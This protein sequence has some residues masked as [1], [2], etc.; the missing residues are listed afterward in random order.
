M[1]DKGHNSADD[2][3]RLLIERIENLEVERKNIAED[4]RDVYLEANAVGYDP[5]IM[6]QV[7]RIRKIKPDD[8][9]EMEALL[10]TYLA[11]LGLD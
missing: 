2:R 6:R 9:R 8:R 7:V 11:A 10:D 3:L 4:I 5:K 1:T